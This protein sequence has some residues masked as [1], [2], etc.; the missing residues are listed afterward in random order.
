[1][2]DQTIQHCIRNG[3]IA[4]WQQ[5]L[6]EGNSTIKSLQETKIITSGLLVGNGVHSLNNPMVQERIRL[7]QQE[8]LDGWVAGIC[9]Q[10]HK[11]IKKVRAYRQEKGH[12]E[13][14]GFVNW[15]PQQYQDCF[16][17]KKK[18]ADTAMPKNAAP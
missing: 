9:K 11:R 4:C 5:R 12:G 7:K 18:D 1:M 8:I 14:N 3:G 6:E 13:E 15:D 2:L 16:Q 17:Y 10:R